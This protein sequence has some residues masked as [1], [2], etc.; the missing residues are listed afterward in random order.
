MG[1]LAKFDREQVVEEAMGVFWTKGYHATSIGDLKE[2]M[3]LQPGSIYGAFGSK[4]ELFLACLEHY[5]AAARAKFSSFSQSAAGQR[6]VFVRIYNSMI[7]QMVTDD[8]CRGCLMINTLVELSSHDHSGGQAARKY[9]KKNQD[10][11]ASILAKAKESG[12]L[13]SPR[14]T[15]ELAAFLIGTVFSL[16]VMGKAKVG[17]KVLES[18]RDQAL[19]QVFG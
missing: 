11:F 10:F 7:D 12:E 6:D 17:R 2:A 19:D 18:I 16:R 3:G 13:K 4:L 1:R 5:S 8:R 14:P 15:E 9:L